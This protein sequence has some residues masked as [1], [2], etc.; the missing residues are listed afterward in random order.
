MPTPGT[1]IARVTSTDSATAITTA[2]FTSAA[3]QLLLACVG[4]NNSTTSSNAALTLTMSNSGSA[5][6]WTV[7]IVKDCSSV[8]F[9]TGGVA[10]AWAIVPDIRVGMTITATVSGVTYSGVSMK[11]Y[12]F[13]DGDYNAA[14]PIGQVGSGSHTTNTATLAAYTSGTDGSRGVGVWLD[15]ADPGGAPTSADTEDAYDTVST[16]GMSMFKAANTSPTGAVTFDVDGPGAG[17]LQAIW[18][19][20]EVKPAAAGGSVVPILQRQYRARRN[21]RKDPARDYLRNREMFLQRAV[22]DT[23]RKTA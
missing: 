8:A 19:A 3:N 12:T 2:G 7:S 21:Y 1:A 4:C 5:L 14:S 23:L 9:D 15:W 22:L 11:P 18:A 13:L 20:V 16:N 17:A 6:S 10:I